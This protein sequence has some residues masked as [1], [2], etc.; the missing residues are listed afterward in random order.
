[1]RS[2]L[3]DWS[4]VSSIIDEYDLDVAKQRGSEGMAGTLEES[5]K[6]LRKDFIL[7]TFPLNTI[8][9]ALVRT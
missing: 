5:A 9:E 2:I 7:P 3:D 6:S 4:D 1:M 8:P